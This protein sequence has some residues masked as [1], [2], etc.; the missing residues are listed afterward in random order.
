MCHPLHGRSK[1]E[2]RTC[3]G[4]DHETPSPAEGTEIICT[5]QDCPGALLLRLPPASSA[6]LATAGTRPYAPGWCKSCGKE[7]S[8]SELNALLAEEDEDRHRWIEALELFHRSE[9]ESEKEADH[10]RHHGESPDNGV[11]TAAKEAAALVIQ[12]LNWRDR[13]LIPNSMRIAEAHDL[14]TR[15]LVVE[16][17]Y[18][19]AAKHCGLAVAVL[20]RRFSIEDR[21]LGME[22]AKLAHICFN[23]GMASP[24]IDACQR[25]RVSLRVYWKEDDEQLV[26]LDKM[27]S[28]CRMRGRSR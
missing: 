16:Q 26:E 12:C 15:L 13:R 23:A 5:D 18:T 1:T 3:V 28:Y 11:S 25:A 2:K 21:E 4:R 24:C 20:E 10:P 7:V 8:P 9:S 17:D 6:L 14:M 27:E 19:R 22:L